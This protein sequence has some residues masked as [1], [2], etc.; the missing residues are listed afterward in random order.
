MLHLMKAIIKIY[1]LLILAFTHNVYAQNILCNLNLLPETE[2]RAYLVNHLK[3]LAG[4]VNTKVDELEKLIGKTHIRRKLDGGMHAADIEFINGVPSW[5]RIIETNEDMI[6]RHYSP[7]YAHIIA[8]TEMLVAGPRQFIL[9]EPHLKQY[10]DDLTG[11]FLTKPELDPHHLWLGYNLNT[12]HVDFTLPRGIKIIDL[13]DGN[14]LIPGA[15]KRADWV[16][17]VYSRYLLDGSIPRGQ[18]DLI[19]QINRQGGIQEAL[20][21]PI[22]KVAN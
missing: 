21:L 16:N 14:F 2:H 12:P 17:D 10:Y 1:I 20:K 15:P 6:F 4:E 19:E 11:I 7:D 3:Q 13:G 8:E 5:A 18:E 9:P 22:F